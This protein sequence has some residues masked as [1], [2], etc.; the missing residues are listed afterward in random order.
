MNKEE[1]KVRIAELSKIIENHNYN[2]YILAQPTISDYDF[3]M[4]L[5]EL[6]SLEKQYPEFIAADSPTQR[7]GGDITKE[8]QTVKHRYPM[9]SLSNSYNIEE[10]KEFINRIKKTIDEEVE[11]VCELK[12]DGISISLT[13]EN[14]IFVK[15]VTRGDGTQGDDVTANVKT[16]R[17]IPL[18]LKGDYPDS[19][20]MRGEIIM[21]HSS[22]NA[23][24]AERED[25][26]LQPF[27]NPRNAAAGT[28]KLQDSKEVAKRK[29]DQYCYFMMM[30]DDKMIFKNHYESLMTAKQWGFN[31]SNFMALCKNAD[32][33]ENF[34][35]EW[36]EKRKEL[37]FDIDGIV[38]K[39]NDFRQRELLGFTAK[40]P[41]WAIAYK[42]KAEEAHT[43]LLSVDFQV[44]RHG[45]IT[46]VANLEPVQLAGTVVK[47][48]T[49]HNAD[50]IEQLDLHYNDFVSVEKGG[51]IIPKITAVDLNLRKDDS[52][53]VTFITHCP[54]CKTQLVKAE[55]ETAW[56]CPNTLGCP[57]QIKG[58]IEHFISRK[59]MNIE[60]LGEGKVEVLFDNGLIKDYSELYG[61]T[62]N[63]IFG[64]EKTI[65]IDSENNIARKVG[66]KEKTSQN[67]ID[68]IEKSKSVPFA[69]VLF[70]L[71]IK[72]VGETTAKLIAKAMGSIDNIINASVEELTEIEE[73]GEKIALSI[74]EFFSDERN[75]NIINKLKEA[76]LQ[77]E[78][79]S[80]A[81][82]TE[83]QVLSGKN[84]VVSGVFS[85]M[86]RDEI[87]QLIEDLGGKNVSSISS[88][89]SF[90]V[91][92]DKMGPEKRK[93]AES[94]GIEIKSEEDFLTMIQGQQTTDK[95]Q[96][97][98]STESNA[99]VQGVLEFDF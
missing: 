18:R 34:I 81:T 46:P 77:F 9:L 83:N 73:V 93:K 95:K 31:V 23:I 89:T 99:G 3:D 36:D 59:A 20:E 19:F 69:R 62:Y 27:A 5:N 2:Y 91:A 25:L 56:Y 64:L 39:V 72:Y 58:R 90:V 74:K 29:L 40:S 24:N 17:T 82:V 88:K 15:A 63:K 37:P 68:A 30:D 98:S 28:I 94:L 21:P 35:N 86:S 12:F 75:I 33:I 87:K 53:K 16:I 7:V 14:G 57:P 70:A 4:L 51:E 41:R 97:P 32:D 92:G 38:I 26:G 50:F 55:G 61:L 1:A 45:T 67:I 8:F 54:E 44:G 22:F 13:Y 85:S 48:A 52:Q 78:Q 76:G 84:I 79:E 6:I 96:Q 42:F 66:F 49:L 43:Q 10:V 71:G 60:S 11:F 47:R 80:K 65:I